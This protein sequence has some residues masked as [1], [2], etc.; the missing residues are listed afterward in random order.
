MSA[1]NLIATERSV[2]RA[3]CQG[4][5]GGSAWEEGMRLLRSYRFRDVT[6][7]MVFEALQQLGTGKPQVIREHLQRRLVLAGFPDLSVQSFFEPHG[8]GYRQMQELMQSLVK[9]S[10]GTAP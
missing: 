9:W 4:V 6:H 8:L 2:L 10:G 5:E 3:M 1:P 7:Q